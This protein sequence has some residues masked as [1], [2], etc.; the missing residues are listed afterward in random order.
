MEL[1]DANNTFNNMRYG[2]LIFNEYLPIYV[3]RFQGRFLGYLI[4]QFKIK[5]YI[6]SYLYCMQI[7]CILKC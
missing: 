3:D 5:L 1:P 6:Y 2:T 7:T 4:I